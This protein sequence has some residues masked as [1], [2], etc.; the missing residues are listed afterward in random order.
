MCCSCSRFLRA[1]KLWLVQLGQPVRRCGPRCRSEVAGSNHHQASR[2]I[3][4]SIFK[5][6]SESWD[7]A[8]K[9]PGSSS[10]TAMP[11]R[12]S[13]S[14]S[15]SDDGKLGILASTGTLALWGGEPRY[16]ANEK[17]KSE[18]KWKSVESESVNWRVSSSRLHA[19]LLENFRT[20]SSG[21]RLFKMAFMSKILGMLTLL[22]CLLLAVGGCASHAVTAKYTFLHAPSTTPSIGEPNT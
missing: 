9:S 12:A 3:W 10:R 18:E 19:L 4:P 14:A 2:H 11:S 15:R 7:G 1:S 17:A 13:A 5:G 20:P 21:V 16:A 22:A 8:S 6:I